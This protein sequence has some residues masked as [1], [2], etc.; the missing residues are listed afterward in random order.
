MKFKDLK[1]KYKIIELGACDEKCT[2]FKIL[3]MANI[4]TLMDKYGESEVL[5][6][7]EYNNTETTSVFIK[8]K[9]EYKGLIIKL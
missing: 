7:K 2:Y 8:D 1:L 5:S 4:D 6:T 3:E 9:E